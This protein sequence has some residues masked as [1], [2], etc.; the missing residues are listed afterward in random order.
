MTAYLPATHLLVQVHL[1]EWAAKGEVAAVL[2]LQAVAQ[3]VMGVTRREDLQQLEQWYTDVAR[4][5][6]S[7]PVPFPGG[8]Y[9]RGLKAVEAVSHGSGWPSCLRSFADDPIRA[10]QPSR[11]TDQVGGRIS[12]V[13]GGQELTM[14]KLDAM[15][16]LH[17]FLMEVKRTSPVCPRHVRQGP[18]NL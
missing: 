2:A 6:T 8:G 15:P 14:E 4:G 1:A 3:D 5:F 12:R 11:T 17:N 7:P 10:V 9:T 16:F 13:V 18:R